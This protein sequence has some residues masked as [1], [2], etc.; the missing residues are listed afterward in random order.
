[1]NRFLILFIIQFV[2]GFAARAQQQP[3]DVFRKSVQKIRS[4][5]SITFSVLQVNKNMLSTDTTI[6]KRHET[7]VQNAAGQVTAQN[8]LSLTQTGQPYHRE[9]LTGGKLFSMELK[10]SVYSK[11]AQ[12]QMVNNSLTQYLNE[13][14]YIIDKKPGKLSRLKDTL[15]AGTCCYSFFA[16][17]YDTVV[18]NQ[19]NYTYKYFYL[20]QKTLL[21]VYCLEKGAGSATKGGYEIGRVNI[22]N[23]RHYSNYALNRAVAPSVFAFNLTGFDTET[24]AMLPEGALAPTV[25]VR[26]LSGMSIPAGHFAGKVVLLQFGSATCAANALANPVMNRLAA[27]YANRNTAIACIYSEETP[28]Q[29]QKYVAANNIKFPIY[30][31]S[32]W[33]K[34]KFQTKGTP[35]FYLI[36]QQGVIVKSIPGYSDGLEQ[37]LS[38]AMDALLVSPPAP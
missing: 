32:S 12:P 1:M 35:N 21:P 20:N 22:Y 24:Q 18:N 25:A 26:Q 19:H 2:C 15:I 31:G 28:L 37:Q 30:L 4:Y 8:L 3:V 27:R 34:K 9:V 5:R 16:N 6:V 36:N 10:D 23:E 38:T 11:A 33:L 14:T 7:I 29:A 13:I 17:T